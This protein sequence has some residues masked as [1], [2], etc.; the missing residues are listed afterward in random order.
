VQLANC[1]SNKLTAKTVGFEQN[2]ENYGDKNYQRYG[3]HLEKY[4]NLGYIEAIW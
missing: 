1:V 3:P 2:R 4:S